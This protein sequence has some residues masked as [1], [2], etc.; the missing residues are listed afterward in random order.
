MTDK[1]KLE[2][3][4]KEQDEFYHIWL[5]GN[6]HPETRG[7]KHLTKKETITLA[8]CQEIAS[9]VFDVYGIEF[10]KIEISMMEFD[11]R[12]FLDDPE[13]YRYVLAGDYPVPCLVN[14]RAVYKPSTN[15]L[16]IWEDGEPVYEN[17]NGEIC[18]DRVTLA[19]SLWW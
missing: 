4:I 19:D 18:R 17:D 2:R 10:E 14:K 11:Y 13:E 16:T 9:K 12:S 7:R 8:K 1:E 3:I 5:D 15:T 6:K